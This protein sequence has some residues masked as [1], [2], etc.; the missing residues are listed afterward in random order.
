MWEYLLGRPQGEVSLLRRM[1]KPLVGSTELR[2]AKS[3]PGATEETQGQEGSQAMKNTTSCGGFSHWTQE[4]FAA[5]LTNQ[6]VQ[7]S[8]I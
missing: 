3:K 2:G 6:T 8:L 1:H 5:S 4:P 7:P